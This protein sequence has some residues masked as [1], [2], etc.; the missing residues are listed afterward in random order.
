MLQTLAN[1]GSGG[2]GTLL[3]SSKEHQTDKSRSNVVRL[4]NNT[5][6]Y[7]VRQTENVLPTEKQVFMSRSPY[8]SANLVNQIMPYSNSKAAAMNTRTLAIASAG[9]S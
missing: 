8:N 3:T 2:F 6:S 1:A 7:S 4:K 5:N 9:M